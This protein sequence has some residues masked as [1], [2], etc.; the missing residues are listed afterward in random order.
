[1]NL[2]LS[3]HEDFLIRIYPRKVE[4]NF[5]LLL[6]RQQQ[7]VDGFYHSQLRSVPYLPD[8]GS[9]ILPNR[10]VI[11]FRVSDENAPF[12]GYFPVGDDPAVGFARVAGKWTPTSSNPR[13]SVVRSIE[14]GGLGGRFSQGIVSLKGTTRF[15]E[16]VRELALERAQALPGGQVSA[17][18]RIATL[19]GGGIQRSEREYA[20]LDGQVQ[21]GGTYYYRLRHVDVFGRVEV[22]KVAEVN[23]VEVPVEFW[24]EQVART[25]VVRFFSAF[26]QRV[27]IKLLD[28]RYQEVALL[29]DDLAYAEVQQLLELT[30]PLRPGRYTLL[31]TTEAQRY[32]QAFY[33]RP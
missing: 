6:N 16:N 12:W 27:K 26:S 32:W 14:F 30:R 3:R 1:L 28:E 21:R 19:K 9:L 7:P 8:T 5:V 33:L 10:Q 17:F 2:E 22:S 31:A 29:Y 23:A 24:M 15:E 13:R 4:G 20:Y 25:P 18:E 11:P